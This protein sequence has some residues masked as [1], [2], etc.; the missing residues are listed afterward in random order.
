M[1]SATEALPL[2]S[3]A[4]YA[5]AAAAA[6]KPVHANQS[7]ILQRMCHRLLGYDGNASSILQHLAGMCLS[8]AG[9]SQVTYSHKHAMATEPCSSMLPK[10]YKG[11]VWV[12]ITHGSPEARRPWLPHTQ[13]CCITRYAG[14][15]KSQPPQL[16]AAESSFKSRQG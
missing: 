4:S 2:L 5:A 14:D 10:L 8:V 13:T 7:Y 9:V 11:C 3:R 1:H 15:G 12:V 6:A 16:A